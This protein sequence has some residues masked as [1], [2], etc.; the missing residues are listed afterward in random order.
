MTAL[1]ADAKAIELNRFTGDSDHDAGIPY[2][3]SEYFELIDWTG[4]AIIDGNK[5]HIPEETPS[6]LH[7]SLAI[8]CLTFN[9][10]FDREL[11]INGSKSN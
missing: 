9:E 10:Q 11:D 7:Q 6:I 1:A 3:L 2:G 5:G 8:R 4:R